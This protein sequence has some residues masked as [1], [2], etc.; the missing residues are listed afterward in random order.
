VQ[1]GV[2]ALAGAVTRQYRAG[3]RNAVPRLV[4]VEPA[5]AACALASISS[6]QLVTIPGPHPSIMVGL[7]C[8]TPSRVAWPH[9]SRGI[10]LFLAVTDDSARRAMRDLAAVGVVSGETG[11]AGLAGL[12]ELCVGEARALRRELDLAEDATALVL[13]TEGAT[14]PRS[15]AAVVGEEPQV[16]GED[17]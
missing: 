6:G 12:S 2:G 3:S 4:A 10:D 15:Y 13:S 11:A 7:N 5:D 1:V 8:D 17:G 14:D 9:V 16:G